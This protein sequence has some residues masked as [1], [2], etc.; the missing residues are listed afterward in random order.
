MNVETKSEHRKWIQIPL[1]ILLFA[2]LG[3]TAWYYFSMYDRISTAN[4]QAFIQGFGPWAPAAFAFLYAVAAPIP[5][6]TVVLSPVGG[7]LFGTLR[8]S[9][10]VISVATFTSLI[11]FTMARRLG[12]EWVASK[13]KGEKLSEIYEKSKGQT[14]FTF[15][16]LMRLI[17]ILPW[18]VQNYVAGLTQ[19]E[20]P[21]YLIATALGIVP[22][23]AALVFLGESITDPTSWQFFA[24][25][26]FN[27][28]IM[29]GA[30]VIARLVMNRNKKKKKAEESEA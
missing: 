27:A 16:L 11:P 2:S 20:L 13:I 6:A 17:P 24:A 26:G 18:E 8:G 3:A 12:R 9:L 30:P 23:S 25:L 19:I 10:L 14:G 22:G 4:V 28:I 29:I 15:V 5:F 7:L 1:I 21:K